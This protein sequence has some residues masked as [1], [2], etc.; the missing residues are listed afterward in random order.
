MARKYNH[1][2]YFHLSEE[3]VWLDNDSDAYM[4]EK[5]SVEENRQRKKYNKQKCQK[6]HS[7]T[8]S[9]KPGRR[10]VFINEVETYTER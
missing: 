3:S 9:S 1:T 10:K 4:Y 7:P 8:R 2:P 5:Q 6:K